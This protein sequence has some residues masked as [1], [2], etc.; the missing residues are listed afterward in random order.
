MGYGGSETDAAQAVGR[1]GDGGIDGII[2]EDPLGLDFIYIQAKRWE[3][4]VGS[5]EIQKFVGALYGKKA[6]KGVFITTSKFTN[7]AINYASQV[8][9]NVVLLDGQMLAKLMIR[10]GVGVSKAEVYEIKKVDS[11]YFIEE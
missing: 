8:N 2:K 11:D 4:S 1:S 5:P 10:H 7:E 9:T 6:N 3:S